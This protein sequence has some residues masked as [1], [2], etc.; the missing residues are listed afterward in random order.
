MTGPGDVLSLRAL[1]RA[2]LAR[3]L[4]LER[5]RRTAAE[6]IEHLVGM[7]AQAPDAPYVGLWNRIDGFTAGELVTLIEQRAAVRIHVMR[8]TVHL[9]TTRDARWLRPL[10]D[11]VIRRS[12]MGQGFPRDLEGVDLDQVVAAARV[13]L[14]E[15]PRTRAALGR[16]LTETWPDHDPGALSYVASYLLPVVQIP[17]RGLWQQRGTATWAVAETWIG[18]PFAPVTER[19]LDDLVLRYLAAF[20]PASVRDVQQWSGLSRL[21]EVTDRLG[22]RGGRL[23]RFRDE[24]GRELLDL[25]DAPRPDPE[26]P[27]PPRF[28]PEYD[29]LLLSHDDRRRV[30]PDGRRVPLPPGNGGSGGML[31]VDGVY[32]AD[33]KITRSRDGDEAT[34]AVEPF[35]G[36]NAADRTAIA[37]EGQKL[38]DF[39]AP[40]ATPT[41]DLQLDVDL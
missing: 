36:L 12:F 5:G 17:P 40:G 7:Q 8:S 25:P 38:L 4:L 26:T 41:L 31:L 30:N 39:V 3:Q 37:D 35:T 13:L 23:R 32:R 14:D 27:A 18:Q 1:G 16:A 2:T 33:W 19:S 22:D 29:N 21:R 9:V 20:G 15:Q 24:D 28:L 11:S 6:V 34:L 10:T